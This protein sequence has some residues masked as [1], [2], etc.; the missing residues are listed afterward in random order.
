MPT[1]TA[2]KMN[3]C[4][5][6]P[7][8]AWIPILSIAELRLGKRPDDG[9]VSV[10]SA[11]W[12]EDLGTWPCDHLHMVNRRMVPEIHNRTGDV[13]GRYMDVLDRLADEGLIDCRA[14]SA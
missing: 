12:G 5:L 1:T 10:T 6:E 8:G 4:R 7:W 14:L 13:C 9:M 3:D 2:T 11:K